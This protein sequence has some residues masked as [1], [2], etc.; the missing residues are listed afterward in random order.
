MCST[1]VRRCSSAAIPFFGSNST[2]ISSRPRFSTFGPRPVATSIRSASTVSPPKCTRRPPSASSILSQ[3]ASRWTAIPRFLNCFRSSLEASSSSIGMSA[4]SISTIVT[5]EPNRS[6]MD[7]NSHPM[8]PPPRMTM[9]L[10]TSCWAS[11]PVESTHLSESM[12]S[13]GGRS[14]D[15]PVLEGHVLAALDG[16]RVR[17]LEAAAALRP[18]DAVGLEEAGDPARELLD[19]ALLPLLR[20]AEVELRRADL[21]AELLERLPGLLEGEGGLHP[22]LGGDA[23]DAQ[24]GAAEGVLLL[25]ADDVGAELGRPDRRRVAPRTAA[26][27]GDVTFHAGSSL[28]RYS[29]LGAILPGLARATPRASKTGGRPLCRPHRDPGFNPVHG[30]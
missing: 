9:R 26:E 8:I 6:R 7:A 12:P 30:R 11:R 25:D 24:A 10:G 15:E 28:D 4:G 23:S 16:D 20:G 17:V 27:N 1:V 22:G 5:S 3:R 13:I 18:L 2:P 29:G 21:D 14:G 19:D